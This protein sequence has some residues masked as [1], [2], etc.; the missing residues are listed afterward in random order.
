MSLVST[1][2]TNVGYR[3]TG[4]TTIS[5]TSD[6][7]AATC[8]AW[9]NET[10]QWITGICAENNSDLG[11]TIGTITTVA[12]DLSAATAASPCSITAT[13]H[14]LI[15][16]STCTAVVKSVVGMT[17]LNDTEYTATYVDANTLT[18]GIDSSAY[19]AYTSGGY[20]SK[21]IFTDLASTMYTPCQQGWIVKDNT[22]QTLDLVSENILLDYD[23]TEAT[24]PSQ[25]YVDGSNNV[26]FPSYPD[27]AYTI[28]IPY[29][30]LP[31]ALT[32]TTDT[33]P[34]LGLMDNVF[35][36]ALTIRSQN[37][38]E[39]DI[40]MELKWQSFL[41]ERVKRVIAMRKKTSLSVGL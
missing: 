27:D 15:S 5:T 39:Y 23:P 13:A 40:T 31:T 14:G 6:P 33:M 26:C 35:I 30:T 36:E 20:I 4:G 12:A 1:I 9:I 34:F 19:T 3:L 8:I 16:S 2:L 17:E 25:F 29:W 18:L 24:E 22:R 32:L 10:A 37:R 11:R 21:R 41:M 38:D 28:K 7:T